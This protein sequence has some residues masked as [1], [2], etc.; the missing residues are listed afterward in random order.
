MLDSELA[1]NTNYKRFWFSQVLSFMANQIVMMALGWH[2]YTLTHSALSLGY[3]GLVLF[4]PQVFL[5]LIVG[6]VADRYNRRRIILITQLLEA[7]ISLSLCGSVL[8]NIES[9]HWIFIAAFCIGSVRAFQ[10]PALQALLP[11]L[12]GLE[13]LPKAIALGS[14][15][16]QFATIAGP[17]LGGLL[18]L[19]GT[20]FVYLCSALFFIV[21]FSQ[22]FSIR[23]TQQTQQ[24]SPATREFLFAGIKF[25]WERKVVL[26]AISLDLFSVLLGG[27]TAL[28][29]IYAEKI[30][31]VG[32]L[33]LGFLRAGPAIG[34][35]I[36][37]IY[38]SRHPLQK[39]A[40]RT[41]FICVGIFGVTTLIFGLSE[42]FLLSLVALVVMGA[43][44]MVSVV[45]RSTLVQLQTPNDMRGRVGAVNS[46]FIGA[47]NQLGEFESGITAEFFGVVPAVVMGGLGTL[48]IVGIWLRLF[49]ELYEWGRDVSR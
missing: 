24:H 31:H 34:A 2:L 9:P 42:W 44:D 22:I 10:G 38:L 19:G 7:I 35:L 46:I 33:G 13:L 14:A 27:A 43:A 23:F 28:L 21:A 48:L 49:P 18:F 11:N 26:G 5:V 30:L 17:A 25:I 20:T 40:G 37:A 47:S 16:R 32:T 1:Q 4:L 3:L 36:L 45:I 6:Q 15:S 41:M 39:N 8:F 29:P 12:V